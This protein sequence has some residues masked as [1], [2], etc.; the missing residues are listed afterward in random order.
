MRVTFTCG[1]CGTKHTTDADDGGS[2]HH[3]CLECGRTTSRTVVV[4][5]RKSVPL[6]NGQY[7]RGNRTSSE[8]ARNTIDRNYQGFNE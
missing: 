3:K 6:Q 7:S 8:V 2:Y 4:V 5:D 1:G